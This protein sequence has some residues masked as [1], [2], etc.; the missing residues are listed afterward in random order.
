MRMDPAE[1]L[2]LRMRLRR[3]VLRCVMASGLRGTRV[4]VAGAGLAGLA[5]ARDLERDGAAVTVIE[6]R[7]RVG[8]RVRTIHDGFAGT[9][10][11]EGGADLIEGEQTQVR[12][13]AA[14]LGLRTSRILK[15][16]WG[17]YGEDRKGRRRARHAPDAFEKAARLL[18]A[19]IRDYQLADGRWDSAVAGALG[20]TSVAEWLDAIEADTGFRSA[21]RGLR[22]FFL[23]DPEDLSLSALVDQFSSGNTPGEG[24]MFRIR[25]GNDRLPRALAASLHSVPLLNTV[26]RR[27]QRSLEKVVVSVD[28]G[29]L[30]EMHAD[31]CVMAMPATTLRDVVFEPALHDEQQRAISQLRYGA[32]TRMLLQFARP[33]WRRP[34]RARAFGTDLPIGAVWDGSE[35]QR[36]SAAILTLLAG[37]RASRELREIVRSEGET[38]VI[39]RL[40]WLGKPARLLASRTLTWEED[41]WSRG[42]YAT[43]DPQFDPALRQWLARPAGRVLFAGEHTSDKWQGY[44]NGAI[45]SGRRAAAEVRALVRESRR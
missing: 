39:Q 18:S 43:F 17:F 44:M 32:A 2:R 45:E 10:H 21:M 11:A 41:E 1:D 27:V 4:L 35:D 20:R 13:L 15:R 40:T 16:G 38:G 24:Q 6:A 3:F 31:Y 22:G 26:V 7:D 14:A 5:A 33:F 12:E 8:G 29:S 37:G 28:G 34:G 25:G 23:A 19:E 9:Q 30:Q 42:G 36:G